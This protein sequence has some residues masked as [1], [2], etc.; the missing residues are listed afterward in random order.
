M[1]KIGNSVVCKGLWAMS[2][3]G[4]NILGQTSEF[5][6]KLL[7]AD[8]VKSS[9]FPVNG[10]YQGWFMLKQGTKNVKI[11]DKE[12]DIFFEQGNDFYKISGH[13]NNKFGKFSLN[14]TLKEEDGTIHLYREYD[15]TTTPSSATVGKK[16]PAST[17]S[18]KNNTTESSKIVKSKNNKS[19]TI[20]PNPPQELGIDNFAV[21][22]RGGAAR[23]RKQ[24]NVMKE[25]ESATT[26]NNN[27]TFP[28]PITPKAA[29]GSLAEKSVSKSQQNSKQQDSN[30]TIEQQQYTANRGQRISKQM[31]KCAE[32]LKELSKNHQA[33]WFL[34]PVDFV[35]L[36]I[37]DY[38]R[39]IS[40]P[41]DFKTISKN[42]EN[43]VYNA[44]ENFL[45]HMRLVFKNAITFNPQQDNPV[46]IA[47]RE[48][49]SKFEDK[50]RVLTTQQGFLSQF[51]SD[52]LSIERSTSRSSVGSNNN[53]TT[54]KRNKSAGGGAKSS[55]TN[56]KN[57]DKYAVAGPRAAPI[58]LPPA[59]ID[60]STQQLIEMQRKMDEMKS[61]LLEL[62]TVVTQKEIQ[63]RILEKK[64]LFFLNFFIF[65]NLKT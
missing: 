30:T 63:D 31:Q 57:R 37:P 65:V 23:V 8:D 19:V 13:G 14:G 40:H 2:D 34:E 36:S 10:R 12:M 4:H 18:T 42:I 35:K 59:A 51:T 50:Y 26:T 46:H 32:L 7:K 56:N 58:F 45:E 6:F 44:P 5:E 29:A 55:Y 60:G 17:L 22:P 43:N 49:S 38:P 61:E 11:E 9:T 25:Y 41:M 64:F 39:I 28:K 52:P 62:R 27:N 16:R 33:N 1:T 3:S 47:A 15:L 54:A 20:N 53:N 24:S 21:T 48:I